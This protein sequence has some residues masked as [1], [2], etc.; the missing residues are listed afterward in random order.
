MSKINTVMEEEHLIVC[1]LEL[2]WVLFKQT[3]MVLR[4]YLQYMRKCATKGHFI[5]LLKMCITAVKM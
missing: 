5:T 2:F 4:M 1:Y 3:L